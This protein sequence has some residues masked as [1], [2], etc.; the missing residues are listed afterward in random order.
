MFE[1][2]FEVPDALAN[3]EVT[4]RI[5]S[6]LYGAAQSKKKKPLAATTTAAQMK[7][8]TVTS[9]EVRSTTA[10]GQPRSGKSGGEVRGGR[11]RGRADAKI[12]S[13]KVWEQATVYSQ[14]YFVV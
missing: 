2:G 11:V 5:E 1:H 6:A 14:T 9:N 3:A 8:G 13:S 4:D 7:V 12:T 10:S